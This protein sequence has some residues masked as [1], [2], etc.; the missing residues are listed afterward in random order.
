MQTGTYDHFKSQMQITF[1]VYLELA[2]APLKNSK[3]K[4]LNTYKEHTER[5]VDYFT[6]P[7]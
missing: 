6:I 1:A 3:T 5:N 7:K 4:Q 2:K